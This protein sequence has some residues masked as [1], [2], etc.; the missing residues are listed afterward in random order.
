MPQSHENEY[1]GFCPPH[2]SGSHQLNIGRK[3]DTVKTQV[4]WLHLCTVQQMT[5][6]IN[7]E[8]S[9]MVGIFGEWSRRRWP[10]GTQVEFWGAD[11]FPFLDV[12]G[13]YIGLFILWKCIKLDSY[14]LKECHTSIKVFFLKMAKDPIWQ[15]H[16]VIEK[17]LFFVK[18]FLQCWILHVDSTLIL[19]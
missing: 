4:L 2:I 14:H 3:T 7:S 8:G 16:W 17:H 10:G 18:E 12:Y 5:N 11:N 6:L 1:M 19:L 13:D 15:I 9:Q